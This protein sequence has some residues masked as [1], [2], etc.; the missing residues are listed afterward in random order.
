MQSGY[1]EKR[2]SGL[3]NEHPVLIF[4]CAMIYRK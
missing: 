1:V 3:L 2:I 4:T